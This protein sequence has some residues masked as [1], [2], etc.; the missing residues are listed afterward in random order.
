MR[1]W[2]KGPGRII[3]QCRDL[4]PTLLQN[5]TTDFDETLHVAWICPGEG[6][7]TTGTSGYSPIYKKGGRRP[8]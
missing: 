1:P 4:D 6:F 5:R 2:P 7:G 8:P 3:T